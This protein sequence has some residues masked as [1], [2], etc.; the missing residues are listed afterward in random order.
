MTTKTVPNTMGGETPRIE[1]DR[2][3]TDPKLAV[4]I[5][6]RLRQEIGVPSY[7]IEPSA[8]AGSFVRA[9]REVWGAGPHITAI[10]VD[11][12]SNQLELEQAGADVVLFGRWEDCHEEVPQK[13]GY[14]DTILVLG[15]PPFD[16][17]EDK[18]KRAKL[19]F[20]RKGEVPT[21]AERHVRLALERLGHFDARQPVPR[22]LAFLVRQS[23]TAGPRVGKGRL[24]GPGGAGGLRHRW[25][26]APRPSFSED[27]GSDGAEYNALV[28]HAGHR[29]AYEGGHIVAPDGRWREKA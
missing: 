24:F 4:A 22:Y 9:A 5:C 28:W 3:L 26:I 25:D 17:D 16:L 12:A 21:T 20:N 29:G 6:A 23:F 27:G 19:P 11:H 7:I 18:R 14:E 8:G 13:V 10:E 1:L 15:N 2:Y